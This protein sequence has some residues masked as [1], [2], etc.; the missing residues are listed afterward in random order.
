MTTQKQ[1]DGLKK[2]WGWN[3]GITKEKN[4]LYGRKRTEETKKK[5]KE[6]LTGKKLS[7][8]HINKLKESHIGQIPWNKGKKG[9][10][11]GW[12]KGKTRNE[13]NR[14]GQPWLGKH[15]SDET[16]EKIKKSH[17]GMKKPWCGLIWNGKSGDKHPR[18]IKDRSKIKKILV[19]HL[20]ASINTGL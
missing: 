1:L 9:V 19:N 8:E 10:Q 15:R 18:W 7:Q 2:G 4:P 12:N 6:A 14:I 16:K 3:K 11:I 20:M 5:I 17:T 13:D